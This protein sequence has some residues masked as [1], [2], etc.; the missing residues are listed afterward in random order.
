MSDSLPMRARPCTADLERQ[1]DLSMGQ[2]S[3]TRPLTVEI[4]CL[5]HFQLERPAS[6]HGFPGKL[7]AAFDVNANAS[8]EP[9]R[10]D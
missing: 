1:Q 2:V 5:R 3:D 6:V 7:S 4:G 8:H 10:Y 9:G